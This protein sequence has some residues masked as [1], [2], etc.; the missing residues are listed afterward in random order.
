MLCGFI[1]GDIS[2]KSL[3]SGGNNLYWP[4]SWRPGLNG[5]PAVYEWRHEAFCNA[6]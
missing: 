4:L 5:R 3:L 6:R 2:D 1:Q